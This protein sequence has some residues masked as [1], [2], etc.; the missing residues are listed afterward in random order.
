MAI[1][2]L[3]SAT[4]TSTFCSEPP[5]AETVL[6]PDVE[7]VTVVCSP[8]P[9][10]S[11]PQTGAPAGQVAPAGEVMTALK[12]A[13]EPGQSGPRGVGTSFHAPLT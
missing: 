9:L 12:A 2:A 6:A 10:A 11:P 7:K 8:V 4:V 1:A 5:W 13:E 3:G